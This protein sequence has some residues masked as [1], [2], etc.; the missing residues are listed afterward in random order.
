MSVD[1]HVVEPAHLL[2]IHMPAQS[3]DRAP[4]MAKNRRGD[5]MWTFE[6]QVVL[7][8]ALES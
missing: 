6:G 5:E 2:D 3:Q 4:K 8:S 7:A 1:D